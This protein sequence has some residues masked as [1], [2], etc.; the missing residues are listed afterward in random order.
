MTSYNQSEPT[1][2]SADSGIPINPSP[3][4]QSPPIIQVPS[5]PAQLVVKPS[6]EPNILLPYEIDCEIFKKEYGEEINK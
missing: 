1:H 2:F 5:P 4:Y 3:L 6:Q